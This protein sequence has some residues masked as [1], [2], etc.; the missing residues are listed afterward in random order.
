[1]IRWMS[2]WV[3]KNLS[4]A[5]LLRETLRHIFPDHWSFFFGEIALYSFVVLVAT[6]VFLAF[7]FS[8]S[9]DLVTYHGS[10]EPLQGVTMTS[11]YESVVRLS[12]DVRAGLLFRQVHHWA[13]LVFAGAVALHLARMFF[14]GAYRL[15]RRLNWL[16]GV[17][18]LLLVLANGFTGYSIPDDLLSGTGLRITFS[19]T[20]SIP[21]I[22]PQLAFLMF[23]DNF[24][25]DHFLTRLYPLHIFLVPALIAA[26]L[27]LHL[28]LL[29][30]QLHTQFPGKRRSE[31]VVEGTRMFPAYALRA[32]GMVCMVA[33]MLSFLGGFFQI[34]PVWLWGPYNTADATVAA[35][36][37]Y[38]TTWLEGA[39]RV[40]P[41]WDIQIGGFLLPAIFWPAVVFPGILFTLFFV[42]P[43]LDGFAL[44]DRQYHNLLN[45][46]C[47]RPGRTA[48]GAGV[49]TLIGMLLFA[50]ANDVFAVA[51]GASQQTLLRLI[52][53]QVIVLPFVVALVTFLACRRTHSRDVTAGPSIEASSA[54]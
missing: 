38:Y 15:P 43:W 8:P 7:F 41:G 32:L 34:N 9:T 42:W 31:R 47:G 44:R 24:P 27:A 21:L 19:I 39:L 36:P 54:E 14:T 37:D 49:L 25:G 1:M 17:G 3:D 51:V 5:R 46:P 20:E 11:A 35:Q 22:G 4:G 26:L 50:G 52:Q 6:G 10:Y 2:R 13:A 45:T 23:G 18:L 28:G 40:F 53:G 12:F 48:L 33:A 16:I 29:W 30:R